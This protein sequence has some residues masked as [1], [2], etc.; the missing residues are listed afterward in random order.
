M[1]MPV[2]VGPPGHVV[3]NVLVTV[4]N[5]TNKNGRAFGVNVI[6]ILLPART[7]AANSVYPAGKG[8]LTGCV[9]VVPPSVD[10]R[11]HKLKVACVV[12]T[13]APVT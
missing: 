9:Q 11:I 7:A 13:S 4:S 3:V 12:P 10:F 1:A 5:E 6:Q 2:A 8:K